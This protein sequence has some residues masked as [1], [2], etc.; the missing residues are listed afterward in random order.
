MNSTKITNKNLLNKNSELIFFPLL[1][2]DG[3]N[4]K[5]SPHFGHAPFFG[6]Y[7]V[8]KDE[9]SIIKNDL[10]HTDPNK[11]PIDQIQEAV[12]PTT[13]FASGIGERAINIIKTKDLNLKTGNY[14][15]VIEVINNLNNLNVLNESC[16][17]NHDSGH[18]HNN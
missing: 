15:T 1:N 16:G 18:H 11:S 3:K 13:I 9:L 7:D 8:E 10:D 2:N 5:I 6:L 14:S 12:N 4:S 17:H